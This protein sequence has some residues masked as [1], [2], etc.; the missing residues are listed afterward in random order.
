MEDAHCAILSAPKHKERAIFGVF[1]GHNGTVAS[2][3]M[4]EHLPSRLDALEDLSFQAI[5]VHFIIYQT[6]AW[7]SVLFHVGLLSP[8]RRRSNQRKAR[9]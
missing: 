1:D 8:G 7:C 4:A 9:G 3:W 5:V 2:T 6:F